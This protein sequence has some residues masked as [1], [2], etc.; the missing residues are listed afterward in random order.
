LLNFVTDGHR[1]ILNFFD[2]IRTSV[3]QLYHF[4]LPFVPKTPLWDEYYER[5]L[6]MDAKVLQGRE[7]QWTPLMRTIQAPRSALVVAYS[8]D[9]CM[10]AT[11]GDGFS[12]LL[13]SR[14]GERLA[15][16]ESDCGYVGSVSFSCDDT[17]V[18]T[19][20][21]QTIRLWDVSTGS[22]ISILHSDDAYVRS[23]EFHPTIGHLL[24]S[25]YHNG[26]VY[27]W[28]VTHGSRTTF[29]VRR[30]E[31]K[32]CWVRY[33][34]QKRALVGCDDGTI[35][36]WDVDPPQQV[37]VFSTPASNRRICS[38]AS[39]CDGLLVAS[40]SADG[41]L[42]VYDAY[43]GTVIYSFNRYYGISSIA[44]SPIAPILIFGSES[45]SLTLISFG[46]HVEHPVVSLDG[47]QSYV[48][49]VAY[50]PNGTFIASGSADGTVRIWGTD[51][52]IFA[53]SDKQH[54]GKIYSAHF[55]DDGQFVV[56]ASD[57]KTVKVWETHTGTLCTTLEG[58]T[59]GARDAIILSD[60][61]RVVSTDK[62]ET[63][64]LWDWRQG[65]ILCRHSTIIQGHG[66]FRFIFPYNNSAPAIDFISTHRYLYD[67]TERA[68][69]CWTIDMSETGNARVV[70]VGRGIVYTSY[71][72]ILRI[73]RRDSTVTDTA[74]PTL[75]LECD[76]GKQFSAVWDSSAEIG[77]ATR[78]LEFI[79]ETE[80]SPLKGTSSERPLT[81]SETPCR[82]SK[83]GAWILDEHGKQIMWLPLAN[84][85]DEYCP[86]HWHMRRLLIGNK[87]GRFT[88][89]DFSDVNPRDDILF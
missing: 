89:I 77:D 79:K 40:G 17:T 53:A 68:V 51:A 28:D 86:M 21:G 22:R 59:V 27:V 29:N 8:H 15:E 2:M 23:A 47:H 11:G 1:F 75:V 50:S 49:S 31:G 25:G 76:S 13:L 64:I 78:E 33:H 60:N 7:I 3:A 82:S 55:S 87:S 24:V 39:S 80:E 20:S 36:I 14:T 10:V 26:Q 32:L 70:L 66:T 57:D 45:N 16:L 85:G 67:G 41:M 6:Y 9:G 44:F 56:S 19:A 74:D 83:A 38:V 35:E 58:H 46:E 37:A 52:T 62:D 12:Q 69:C 65:R 42:V 81:A 61:T 48:R 84:R 63:L 88:L 18:A 73:S 34:D 5:E 71:S 30:S 54:L 72:T 4:A 43:T